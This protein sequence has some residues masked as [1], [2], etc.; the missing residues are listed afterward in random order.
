MM[1]REHRIIRRGRRKDRVAK[2]GEEEAKCDVA[3][4]MEGFGVSSRR[5]GDRHVYQQTGWGGD[6]HKQ[7]G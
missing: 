2:M 5:Q 7:D 1:Y 4:R 3:L 6:R